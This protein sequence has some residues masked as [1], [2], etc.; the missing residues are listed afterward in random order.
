MPPVTKNPVYYFFHTP[1]NVGLLLLRLA[2]AGIF[3][4]HGTQKAFGWFG[5][6]GWQG[7]IER[8]ASPEGFGLPAVLTSLV[9][10]LEVAVCPSLFFGFL[11]RLGG[12]AVVAVMSGALVVLGRSAPGFA[13]VEFPFILWACGFALLCAGGGALSVDRAISKNLLPV[14]G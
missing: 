12:L 1:G 10:V 9:I 11:T 8:F 4:F 2:V 3:F 13:G 14:V 7:T 6:P 5:G